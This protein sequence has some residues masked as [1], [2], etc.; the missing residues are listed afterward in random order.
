VPFFDDGKI[1]E[2]TPPAGVIP[3]GSTVMLMLSVSGEVPDTVGT[4]PD[5]AA[6]LL[7]AYGYSVARREYTTAVGADG[8]VVGTEPGAGTRLAPGSAVT[9]TVNGTPPP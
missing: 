1:V 6:K 2:Q 9:L 7:Q 3:Q 4:T 5:D 8:K